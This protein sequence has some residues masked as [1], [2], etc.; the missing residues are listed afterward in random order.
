M[1]TASQ[2][3]RRVD[4]LREQIRYHEHRYYVLN[5]PEITDAQFDVL[6]NELRRARG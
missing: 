3:A 6:M 2:I 4:A 1:P 5:D